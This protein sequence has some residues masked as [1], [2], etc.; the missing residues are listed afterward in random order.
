LVCVAFFTGAG[1]AAGFACTAALGFDED[2][3]VVLDLVVAFAAAG[4]FAGAVFFGA[5]AVF[6]LATGALGWEAGLVYEDIYQE[7]IKHQ[8]SLYTSFAEATSAAFALGVSLTRPDGPA[9]TLSHGKL[10][11]RTSHTF[12]KA[13]NFLVCTSRDGP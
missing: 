8:T 12:R 5:T 10:H 13:E 9:T 3:L 6:G 1:L 2:A 4:F 11:L 7:G